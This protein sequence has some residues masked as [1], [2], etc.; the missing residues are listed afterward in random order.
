VS[1]VFREPLLAVVKFFFAFAPS[2][3][4]WDV[5]FFL[6]V[7]AVSGQNLYVEVGLLSA[8]LVTDFIVIS[9]SPSS[10][11]FEFLSMSIPIYIYRI[12]APDSLYWSDPETR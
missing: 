2:F 8:S 3:V 7:A 5:Y 6:S 9:A 1:A 4:L 12:N 10:Q 11:K